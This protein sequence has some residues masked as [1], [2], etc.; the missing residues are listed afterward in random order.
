MRG[1][2][3]IVRITEPTGA[4]L[5][6]TVEHVRTGQRHRFVDAETLVAIITRIIAGE[7]VARQSD[8]ASGSRP[9]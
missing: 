9:R 2:S 8:P 4:A 7:T 5:T 3:F 1:L 6:G